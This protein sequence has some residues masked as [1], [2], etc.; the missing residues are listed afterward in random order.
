MGDLLASRLGA[1][2]ADLDLA[3][4]PDDVVEVIRCALVHNLSVAAAGA[5]VVIVGE[6]WA[7]AR[8]GS[9]ARAFISGIELSPSDA[10]F[11]NGCLVHARAQDDTYFPGLTHVGAATTPAVVALAEQSGA[12]VG[13][14]L[15]GLV[16]GYEVAGSI[17]SVAAPVSTA[18]GFRAS[19]IYGPFASAA[20]SASMLS[21]D[22][23]KAAHA[24]AIASS[25]SAGTN[26]TWVGGSSEWQLQLG[27][28]SRVGLDSAVLAHSGATGSSDAFEG[29]SGFY[30][31]YVRDASV[32]EGVG[33]DLGST[34][35]T[36]DVTFKAHPVCAILQT[37]VEAAIEVRR[38][39]TDTR[40]VR[41]SLRLSPAEVAYPGTDGFPPFSDVGSALMSARFCLAVALANGV[42]TADDLTRSSDRDLVA[43][44]ER[45]DVVA[46]REL[47]PR[48]FVLE[49]EWADGRHSSLTQPDGRLGPWERDELLS[50]L[51]RLQSEISGV[52]L[53]AIADTVFGDLDAPASRLV[54]S[55]VPS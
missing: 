40:F 34:W 35:R 20:G 44:S 17:G 38:D 5:E 2:V 55:L 46:D 39:V 12:S 29:A 15:V 10:A 8:G 25:F 19:G 48:E 24:I 51:D 31:A 37:P 43:M 41:A 3:A 6:D 13:D 49:V 42:V 52:D 1:F 18:H 45:V 54:D 53:T 50:H 9:G 32:A 11:V 16:A 14:V 4:I 7:R 36:K 26:Q 47:G 28:A 21:L 22:A 33:H 27:N 30:A 23:G